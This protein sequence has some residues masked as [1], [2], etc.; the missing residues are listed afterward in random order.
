MTRKNNQKTNR[1]SCHYLI[2]CNNGKSLTG[3]K[4][5]L[6]TEKLYNRK[7]TKKSKQHW[8]KQNNKTSFHFLSLNIS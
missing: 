7:I 2:H 1:I 8:V 4:P 3:K 6:L 5:N